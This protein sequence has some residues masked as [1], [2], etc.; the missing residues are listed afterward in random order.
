[1]YPSHWHFRCNAEKY[2]NKIYSFSEPFGAEW[3]F[4]YVR[5][6][7][8][9]LLVANLPFLSTLWKSVFGGLRERPRQA[10]AVENMPPFVLNSHGAVS[11]RIADPSVHSTT[12]E[13][14][15][16]NASAIVHD[17]QPQEKSTSQASSKTH[18]CT[19]PSSKS[20]KSIKSFV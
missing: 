14:M 6:S 2:T 13:Q 16:V 20:D 9:A 1:M 19:M 11:S 12:S 5:E 7:S 3:T 18:Q 15:D 17:R 4:W 8:T 10:T